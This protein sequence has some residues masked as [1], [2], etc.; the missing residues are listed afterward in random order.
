MK[1]LSVFAHPDDET[2]SAGGSFASLVKQGGHGMA[3]SLTMDDARVKEFHDACSVLGIEHSSFG[4]PKL[5]QANQDDVIAMLIEQIQSFKPDV[6]VTHQIHD[7][8][9]EHR[10]TRELTLTAIEWASHVT[11]YE[12]A[13]Q[14]KQVYE[15][16]TVVLLPYPDVFV[17]ISEVIH[18]KEEAIKIYTSQSTKGGKNFYLEFQRTRTRLRG[19]LSHV[20]HAEAFNNVPITRVSPFKQTRANKV[21]PI[22]Q[23]PN[24]THDLFS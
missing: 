19:L 5:S 15:A 13:H 21:F 3:I 22:L 7:Y 11:Q 4:Y 8:H 12:N 16:E 17:D 10:L 14:V 23:E 20:E 6:V 18:I 2:F 9:Y 1:I 24:D